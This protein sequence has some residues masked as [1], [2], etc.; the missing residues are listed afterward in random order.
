MDDEGYN[1]FTNQELALFGWGQSLGVGQ[2]VGNVYNTANPHDG[3]VLYFQYKVAGTTTPFTFNGFD[4]H[5]YGAG[6]A[7][8]FMLE[9]LD[10]ANHVL[11]SA[12]LTVVGNATQSYT[13][14]TL[15]W[16]GVTTVAIVSGNNASGA[17]VAD[18][19]DN[20]LSMDNVVINAPVPRIPEPVSI[21]VLATGLIGL[22]IARLERA[23]RLSPAAL[24]L[25]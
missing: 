15:N 24:K 13:T 14:E 7:T 11:D 10:A 19:D 8:R 21:A 22:A 1:A 23:R 6:T 16:T 20:T 4:L 9:G 3:S 2:Q 18:W 5:T 12:I 25:K 17:P